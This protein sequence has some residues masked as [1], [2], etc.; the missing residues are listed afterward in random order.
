MDGIIFKTE[1][2]D[3]EGLSI[4]MSWYQMFVP[5]PEIQFKSFVSVLVV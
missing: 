2:D 3:G 5:F 4:N 1:R